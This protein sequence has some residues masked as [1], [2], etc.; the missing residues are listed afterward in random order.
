M[1]PAMPAK[2]FYYAAVIGISRNA[3]LMPGSGYRLALLRMG[4]VVTDLL[5]QFLPGSE[6]LHFPAFFK[7]IVNFRGALV[8]HETAAGRNLIGASSG[9]VPRGRRN[10]HHPQVDACRLDHPAVLMSCGRPTP[11]KLHDRRRFA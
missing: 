1:A 9:F 2:N 6:A 8:Q 7:E 3:T 4:Q 10:A 11:D 5:R